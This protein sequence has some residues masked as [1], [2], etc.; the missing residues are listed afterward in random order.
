MGSLSDAITVLLA[1]ASITSWAMGTLP[2]A[3]SDASAGPP[4]AL[5]LRGHS[6]PVAWDCR[7][8]IRVAV[9]E[10]S[11]PGPLARV[12]LGELRDVAAEFSSRTPFELE[13][14]GGTSVVPTRQWGEDLHHGT[15][16][17]DVVVYFGRPSDTDLMLPGA[18]AVGGSFSV[19]GG[20]RS[21]DRAYLGYVFIDATHLGD[22]RPGHGYLSRG[23]LFTHEFLHVLGLDHTDH[24]DSMMNSLIS[25]STGE[26]GNG[27]LAGLRYLAS[28]GCDH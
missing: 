4:Y 24:P 8:P 10:A 14:V 15:T 25:R 12:V 18:A 13:I 23:A 28:L 22:Y 20:D 21:S 27:D 3:K 6:N 9:N 1:C 5:L 11:L 17:V 7:K 26:M 2:L 19:S 16:D